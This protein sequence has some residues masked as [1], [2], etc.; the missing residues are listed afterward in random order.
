M[1]GRTFAADADDISGTVTIDWSAVGGVMT[2]EGDQRIK[3]VRL[4]CDRTRHPVRC[5]GRTG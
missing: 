1:T 3:D 4:G 2:L 5:T